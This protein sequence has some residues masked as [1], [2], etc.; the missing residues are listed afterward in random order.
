MK[1]FFCFLFV[2]VLLPVFSLADAYIKVETQDRPVTAHYSVFVDG[3]ISSSGKGGKLFDFDSLCIDLYLT[4]SED[5]AYLLISNCTDHLIYSSGLAKVSVYRDGNRAYF[6]NSSGL[7]VIGEYDENGTDIWIDYHGRS[8]RL[9]PVY[10]F[11][12]YSDWK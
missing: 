3:T 9:S 6:C 11:S 4:D 10:E 2:L 7:Y 8:F 1:R 5:Y 12:S